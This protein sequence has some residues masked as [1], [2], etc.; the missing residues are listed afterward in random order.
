MEEEID[1][2]ELEEIEVNAAIDSKQRDRGLQVGDK[3]DEQKEEL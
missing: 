2:A 1:L 3:N